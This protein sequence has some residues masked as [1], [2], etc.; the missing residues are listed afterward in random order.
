[1]ATLPLLPHLRRE[2]KHYLFA[3]DKHLPVTVKVLELLDPDFGLYVW[4]SSLVLAEF[5]SHHL[6]LFTTSNS[7]HPKII[8]ELGA[9]TA[10]PTLLLARCTQPP[11]SASIPPFLIATDRPEVPRILDNIREALSANGIASL[12]PEAPLSHVMVRGLGWG[13]FSLASDRH[14]QGGLFQLLKDVSGVGSGKIDF[15]L[16]S[17]TFYNPPDFE[18]LLATVSYILCHHNPESVFLTTYQDRSAKRNIDHLLQKWGLEAR[19]IPWDEFAFDMSKYIVLSDDDDEDQGDGS[20]KDE[21]MDQATSEVKDNQPSKASRM[22]LVN[23]SSG[24][25]SDE[26]DEDLEEKDRNRE[27]DGDMA[28]SP[29]RM[30]D[31]GAISSVH[32]LWICKQGQLWRSHSFRS[33]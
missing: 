28:I 14:P 13:D 1:M 21:N 23:Y 2:C 29:H 16:G 11:K 30:G 20:M 7:T 4:P 26:T 32:L 24:S 31:G 18:P 17:D 15:I 8:L 9:G 10:L 19:I 5:I 25:E 22:P 6:C 27:L 33:E 3:S 12:Y